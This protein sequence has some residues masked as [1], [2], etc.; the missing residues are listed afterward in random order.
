MRDVRD[1][2][3]NTMLLIE[4]PRRKYSASYGP[5]WNAWV[6]TNGIVPSYGLNRAYSSTVPYVY[7]FRAGSLHEGGLHILLGDGGVRFLSENTDMG[8][9]RGL[10][11][12]NGSEVLG[13]F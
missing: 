2:T 3:T 4:T 13:E 11:S 6:Y 8:I 10:V 1:G 9:V 5:F 12:I 7:A